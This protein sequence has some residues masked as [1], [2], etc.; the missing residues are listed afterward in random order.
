MTNTIPPLSQLPLPQTAP[1]QTAPAQ[2][3]PPAETAGPPQAPPAQTDSVTLSAAAQTSTQLLGAA[4]ASEGINHAAV[5]QIRGALQSGTYN[6]PPE[7]LAQAIATVLKES[8]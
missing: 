8:K 3:P 5:V 6:V 4:R 7:K 1:A 2:T